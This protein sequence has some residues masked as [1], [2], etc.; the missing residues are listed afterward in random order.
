M[1][2]IFVTNGL[3]YFLLYCCIWCFFMLCFTNSIG[4]IVTFVIVYTVI[5]E[6]NIYGDYLDL[7]VTSAHDIVIVCH[8]RNDNNDR[9]KLFIISLLPLFI[10]HWI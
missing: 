4:P 6:I 2:V 5:L 9:V 8:I 7:F 3:P 10:W 1:F